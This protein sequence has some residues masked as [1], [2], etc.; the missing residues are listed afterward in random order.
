[1]MFK[2]SIYTQEAFL[3]IRK[4]LEALISKARKREKISDSYQI[5]IIN[6]SNTKLALEESNQLNIGLE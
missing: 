1:M 5:P 2:L 4:K 6:S 3:Y